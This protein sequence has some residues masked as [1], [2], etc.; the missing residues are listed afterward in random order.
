MKLKIV[1]VEFLEELE[2]Q[3]IFP[4]NYCH[5]YLDDY[6][7]PGIFA[8][9]PETLNIQDRGNVIQDKLKEYNNPKIEIIFYDN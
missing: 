3:L 7:F 1:Q 6:L 2:S 4:I 9:D 8:Y 5:V